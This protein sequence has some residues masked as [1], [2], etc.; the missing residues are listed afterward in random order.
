MKQLLYTI[1][2]YTT[3]QVPLVSCLSVQSLS[4]SV[5]YHQLDIFRKKLTKFDPWSP[6]IEPSGGG[7]KISDTTCG[8]FRSRGFTGQRPSRVVFSLE[9]P[10]TSGLGDFLG[11]RPSRVC[12][13]QGDFQAKDHH[14]W[15]LAWKPPRPAVSGISWAKE[16]H[17]CVSVEGISRPK[18]ITSV[19]LLPQKPHSC[20]FIILY[21]TCNFT[22]YM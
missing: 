13:G 10:S 1:P 22:L 2:Y 19:F 4:D 5:H 21:I 18:T 12:F 16:H 3:I 9:T 11:Q 15:S 14:E 6:A 8:M 17:E 7:I 20:G